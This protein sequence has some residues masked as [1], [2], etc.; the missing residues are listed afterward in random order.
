MDRYIVLIDDQ[1]YIESPTL[2][3]LIRDTVNQG[4]CEDAEEFEATYGEGYIFKLP[5]PLKIVVGIP[6]PIIKIVE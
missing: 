4:L 6:D 3:D 5:K 2:L 1:Y